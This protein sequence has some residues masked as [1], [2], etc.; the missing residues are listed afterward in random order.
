M[1]DWKNDDNPF[2]VNTMQDRATIL[3]PTDVPVEEHTDFELLDDGIITR[4]GLTLPAWCLYSVREQ[5]LKPVTLK[6]V[7]TDP[8]QIGRVERIVRII[9]SI[10]GPAIVSIVGF[11][12]FR[13][14]NLYGSIFMCALGCLSPLL[15]FFLRRLRNEP[16]Q[17]ICK[18]NGFVIRSRNRFIFSLFFVISLPFVI[19]MVLFYASFTTTQRPPALLMT[20]ANLFFAL[21]AI[22]LVTALIA[23]PKVRLICRKLPD[24][25]FHITGFHRKYMQ[26]LRQNRP[27]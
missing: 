18:V 25:R 14:G 20:L 3:H 16:P 13:S 5:S 6:F 15:P 27:S 1:T 4:S 11:E 21:A 23:L 24:G 22:L 19:A 10:A 17:N 7:D 9:L 2:A 12:V 26:R 8:P